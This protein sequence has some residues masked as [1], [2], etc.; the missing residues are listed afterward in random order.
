MAGARSAP[1]SSVGRARFSVATIALALVGLLAL[2]GYMPSYNDREFLP[3]GHPRQPRVPGRRPAFPAG[4]DESRDAAGGDR[5]RR[6]QLGRHARHRPNCQERVPH[7]RHRPGAD[8]HQAAGHTDRAHVDPVPDQHAGHHPADEPGLHGQ[9]HG[10]HADPGQRH[11]DDH[12]HD[13]DD[14]EPDPAD[15]GHHAQHGRE[16]EEHGRRHRRSAGQHREFRRLLPAA[17]QLL[18]LGTALLRHP[19]LLFAAVD[20]RHPRRHRRPDRRRPATACP[21]WTRWTR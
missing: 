2:P 1:P 12:R 13:G 15:G 9:G 20:L 18:L 16:D 6:A 14:A 5:P 3:D 21:T 17:P 10:E 8:H 4:A 19:G 7:P 11:A